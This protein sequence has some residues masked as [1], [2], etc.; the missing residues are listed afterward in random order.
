M[1]KKD[2]I[3]IYIKYAGDSDGFAR[4]ATDSEMQILPSD[5]W[6]FIDSVIDDIALIE[7]GTLSAKLEMT[8]SERVKENVPDAYLQIL[9]HFAGNNK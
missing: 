8:I 5:T 6:A 7:N 4:C 1:V 9:I 2:Q 3:D